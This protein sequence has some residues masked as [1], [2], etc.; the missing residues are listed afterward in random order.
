MRTGLKVVSARVRRMKIPYMLASLAV[1][2]L[3]VGWGLPAGV[4]GANSSQDVVQHLQIDY[5]GCY[6][7]TDLGMTFCTVEKGTLTNTATP[8]GVYGTY[9][10]ARYYELTVTFDA[11]P[12]A[13]IQV[14]NVKPIHAAGTYIPARDSINQYYYVTYD[15]FF[16]GTEYCETTWYKQ[17]NQS[18]IFD[19][20]S[21]VLGACS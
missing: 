11:D 17:V 1:A 13:V 15:V 12:T 10:N 14:T 6:H 20:Y 3:A 8:S 21:L 5:S 19:R 16:L 2:T 9:Y 4:A 18:L 7:D